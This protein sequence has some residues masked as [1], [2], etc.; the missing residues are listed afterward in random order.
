MHIPQRIRYYVL[1]I[2]DGS[3]RI[4]A[5][6]EPEGRLTAR[7]VEIRLVLPTDL[8]MGPLESAITIE[9]P[10][11][12][13]R[14]AHFDVRGLLTP[15]ITVKPRRVL[16]TATEGGAPTSTIYIHST[17]GRPLLVKNVSCATPIQW[18]IAHHSDEG[19]MV[20]IHLTMTEATVV[21]D[22]IIEDL[23]IELE[24]GRTTSVPMVIMRL[25]GE[26]E[27]HRHRKNPAQPRSGCL[28]G[29]R[30]S[31]SPCC[32]IN[33]CHG[34]TCS[35]VARPSQEDIQSLRVSSM[36]KEA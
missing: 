28:G 14:R 15:G 11:S 18:V 4:L 33:P 9:V 8:S 6:V 5:A 2:S 35:L 12:P 13:T 34:R 7:S 24:D 17:G 23:K 30:N 32:S 16:V 22:P 19:A 20:A 3:G 29:A 27:S 21:K 36:G 25:D 10:G 31:P 26:H 1:T